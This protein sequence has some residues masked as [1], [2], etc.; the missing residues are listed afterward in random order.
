MVRLLVAA[1]LAGLAIA[2][3]GAAGEPGAPGPVNVTPA[4]QTAKP[5]PAGTGTYK[6][7][8]PGYGY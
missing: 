7:Q 6:E 5:T 8:D 4:V 3:C 2:A 1:Y